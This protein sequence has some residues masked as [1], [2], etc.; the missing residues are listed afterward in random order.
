MKKY[1]RILGTRMVF[2]AFSIN[3]VFRTVSVFVFFK[4]KRTISKICQYWLIFQSQKMCIYHQ[5][6][7]KKLFLLLE[8]GMKVFQSLAIE[9]NLKHLKIKLLLIL[10]NNVNFTTTKKIVCFTKYESIWQDLTI[11]TVHFT[12]FRVENKT[13]KLKSLFGQ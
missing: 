10:N 2:A 12:A 8:F 4:Q 6:C 9:I 3:L 7:L 5:I 1:E 11:Q 13:I